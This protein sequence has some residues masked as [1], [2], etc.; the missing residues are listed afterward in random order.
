MIHFERWSLLIVGEAMVD[1]VALFSQFQERLG[2]SSRALASGLEALVLAGL[3]KQEPDDDPDA[4]HRYHLTAKGQDLKQVVDALDQ[5][6][7]RWGML[8]PTPAE[9]EIGHE[10]GPAPTAAPTDQPNGQPRSEAEPDA[11]A[12]LL[13][14]IRL[15]GSFGLTVAGSPVRDVSIGSQRLLA[16]L[17]LHDRSIA[18][19]ALAGSMWPEVSDERAGVSLRA[20]LSRLDGPSRDAVLTA[21]AGLALSDLVSVDLHEGQALAR[22]LLRPGAPDDADLSATAV[23]LLSSELLPDWYDD[24]VVAEAEDWRQLRLTGLETLADRLT[25]LGRLPEAAGAARAAM[26]VDPLR[27]SPHASLVRIHLAEGN[28]SE[29]LRVY[30]RYRNLLRAAL[31]LEPTALLTNLLVGIR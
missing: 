23:Q 22:R 15:L 27:E 2:I 13:I 30:A 16:F 31:D 10:P 9:V 3:M 17:A 19:V 21:S 7:N 29:A 14:E 4:D 12:D 6:S 28:Q 1:G 20:A 5:W 25:D 24:W 18:R 8:V 26:K 11:A